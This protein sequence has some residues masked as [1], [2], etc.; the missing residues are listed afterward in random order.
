MSV[1]D[2]DG[3]NLLCYVTA[4]LVVIWLYASISL[5]LNKNEEDPDPEE[6]KWDKMTINIMTL[7]CMF[8]LGTATIV[9]FW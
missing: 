8:V 7:F 3:Y 6:T 9:K 4:I 5:F 1:F 2:V